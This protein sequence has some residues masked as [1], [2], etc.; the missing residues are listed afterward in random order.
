MRRPGVQISLFL[1]DPWSV[2][3]MSLSCVCLFVYLEPQLTEMIF[4]YSRLHQT[5]CGN[6][7]HDSPEPSGYVK[8]QSLLPGPAP[9]DNYCNLPTSEYDPTYASIDEYQQQPS[10][11]HNN[12]NIGWSSLNNTG[13][14]NAYLL[15]SVVWPQVWMMTIPTT[16]GAPP[17][18]CLNPPL[19]LSMV[20]VVTTTNP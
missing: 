8:R 4:Q 20:T 10:F 11:L 14:I 16:C 6:G 12:K 19:R 3:G 13:K 9:S 2:R 7:Y 18:P 17:T 5:P 1:T 15:S